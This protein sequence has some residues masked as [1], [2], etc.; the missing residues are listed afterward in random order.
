MEFLLQADPYFV[1][2]IP[3]LS[4]FRKVEVLV[5]KEGLR[6]V[7]DAVAGWVALPTADARCRAWTLNSQGLNLAGWWKGR[8]MSALALARPVLGLQ[9]ESEAA[10]AGPMSA[11]IVREVQCAEENVQRLV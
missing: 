9:E 6:G 3:K 7:G 10:F 2:S 4:V 11:A 5:R 8:I 1:R